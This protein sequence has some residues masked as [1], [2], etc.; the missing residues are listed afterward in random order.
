[1]TDVNATLWTD[2]AIRT[3][4]FASRRTEIDQWRTDNAR[5]LVRLEE[6]YPHLHA[7]LEEAA[8][9]VAAGLAP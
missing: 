7:R 6:T 2:V 5:Y 4:G 8:A 3:L 9:Q 1:M